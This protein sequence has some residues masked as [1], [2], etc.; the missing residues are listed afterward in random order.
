MLY[1]ITGGSGSG[2]SKY[3]ENIVTNIQKNVK[4]NKVYYV[5][6]MIPYGD[7]TM[8]KIQKHIDMRKEKRFETIECFYD[9]KNV[10]IEKNS[11]VL[12]ECMS[13]LLANLMYDSENKNLNYVEEILEQIDCLY[14]QMNT[15]I[16]VSNEIFSDGEDYNIDMKLYLS[17][18]GEI[19]KRIAEKANK[20]VEVVYSIPII[21]KE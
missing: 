18:L 3:A 19:N 20:V 15:L 11:I 5:A 14:N 6:T 4:C 13:N 9:L 8:Q 21:I 12:L 10:K 17:N 1:L 2:K 7:E 16:I